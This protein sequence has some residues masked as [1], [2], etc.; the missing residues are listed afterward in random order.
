[1]KFVRFNEKV[2]ENLQ[3]VKD[4][5]VVKGKEYVRNDN[6]FHNFERAAK[7][8]GITPVEAL[9]GM[10]L[11]H[12]VSYHDMIDDIKAGKIPTVATVQ[13]KLGDI[14]TYFT[15]QKIQLEDIAELSD[16]KSHLDKLSEELQRKPQVKGMPMF[17]KQ[18]PRDTP[19]RV[20]NPTPTNIKHKTQ[21]ILYLQA[22]DTKG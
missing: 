17:E 1:M 14:I 2:D 19:I 10:L 13:E 3:K 7:M 16:A 12:L 8:K 21:E 22:T 6:P 9:D 4:T 15:L 5:L 11:K 20:I 18:D